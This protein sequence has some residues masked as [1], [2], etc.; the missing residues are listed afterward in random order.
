[1]QSEVDHDPFCKWGY[2]VCEQEGKN[3]S[4][5]VA[6]RTKEVILLLCPHESLPHEVAAVHLAQGC[7]DKKDIDLLEGVQRRP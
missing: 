4:L 2:Y 3:V 5:D 7:Q 1:M 6:I